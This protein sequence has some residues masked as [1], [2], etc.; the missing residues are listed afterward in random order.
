M[1]LEQ[2]RVA[3]LGA[4]GSGYAAASLALSRGAEVSVYDSGDE[5]RL[6]PAVERFRELGCLLTTGEAALSPDGEFDLAVISPGIDLASP[7]SREFSRVSN[8]LIGEVEFANRLSEVP[9]IAITGT[10]GKTTTTS[11]IAEML[12]S[13]GLSVV[14]A[15]N[16]GLAYS[17]VVERGESLD[18]IVLEVSSFQLESISQFSPRISIWMNFAPDHMDRYANLDEY[19]SAKQNLFR[20]ADA[21]TTVI[22]KKEDDVWDGA[23]VT[24]S[25]FSE[26]GAFEYLDGMIRHL[27]TGRE[28]SFRDCRLHGKHNAENVMVALAVADELGLSWNA[29]ANAIEGFRAPAHRCEKV[30]ELEG[31]IFI[32]DSKSTNLH[33]LQSALAGQ[34]ASTVL[35]VGGKQKGLDF[36]EVRPLLSDKV[37]HAVCLG[38]IGESIADTWHGTVPATVVASMDEAVRLAFS[39][40][41]EGDVVLFSPGTSSFDMYPGY[42]ARGDDFRRAVEALDGSEE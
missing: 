32:N 36:S 2:K 8:E 29:V 18:W 40:A 6:A 12:Q 22:R 39:E 34:E 37:R 26:G 14:A 24:F 25:A 31:V 23:A 21:N 16:I 42:E 9:V 4:G 13:T 30:R 10:N 27:A 7:I 38:E 35:I 1:N 11:L 5:N 3:I 20:N 41:D 33:S 28:F 17:E 19:R 15:G